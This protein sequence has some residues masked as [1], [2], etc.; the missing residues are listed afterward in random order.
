MVNKLL[1]LLLFYIMRNIFQRSTFTT[2]QKA[3][4]LALLNEGVK[5]KKNNGSRILEVAREIGVSPQQVK[6]K[7]FHEMVGEI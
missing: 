6:V 2:H 3:K 7:I 5:R 1:K 4:M